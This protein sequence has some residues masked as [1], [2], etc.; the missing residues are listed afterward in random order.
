MKWRKEGEKER[1]EAVIDWRSDGGII[2]AG[3]AGAEVFINIASVVVCC[4]H[5]P[6]PPPRPRASSSSRSVDDDEPPQS[7]AA[8]HH[9]GQPL[10]LKT[11]PSLPSIRGRHFSLVSPRHIKVAVSCIVLNRSML[12]VSMDPG[13]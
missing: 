4:H 7:L 2:S 3:C 13:I 8:F 5:R 11:G 1:R 9:Y 12:F 10:A 6:L